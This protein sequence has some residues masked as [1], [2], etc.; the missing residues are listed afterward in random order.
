M[1]IPHG[2]I[3]EDVKQLSESKSKISVAGGH[4]KADVCDPLQ[5]LILLYVF[6]IKNCLPMPVSLIQDKCFS[7]EIL[8]KTQHFRK[9]KCLQPT[10]E[11]SSISTLHTSDSEQRQ[12]FMD[13]WVAQMGLARNNRTKIKRRKIIEPEFQEKVPE[14]K[15]SAITLWNNF[16]I[17]EAWIS[18]TWKN[19]FVKAKV[20]KKSATFIYTKHCFFHQS[21][22]EISKT[23]TKSWQAFGNS[24]R[25]VCTEVVNSYKLVSCSWH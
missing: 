11:T 17:I 2:F 25:S 23:Y 18:G 14:Y 6:L 22:Q 12:L 1:R 9:E 4:K 8:C 10:F 13:I 7:V 21:L 5:K 19:M 3:S 20:G 16:Q 15:N 24:L